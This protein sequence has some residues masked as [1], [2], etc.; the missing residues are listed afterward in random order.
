M[1]SFKIC[2]PIRMKLGLVAIVLL[3]SQY[4][5]CCLVQSS[6]SSVYPLI[7]LVLDFYDNCYAPRPFHYIALFLV[8][9]SINPADRYRRDR[10]NN[11]LRRSKVSLYNE[12]V[13]LCG[14]GF[15]DFHRG[16]HD[17]TGDKRLFHLEL[18]AIEK[19]FK[20]MADKFLD[21]GVKGE[22]SDFVTCVDKKGPFNMC[23]E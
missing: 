11:Y 19:C 9:Q 5:E 2:Q 7:R 20:E 18:Q 13:I 17:V 3:A 4:V 12:G 8:K 21:E 22:R 10:V 6:H 16:V 1:R 23:I 15:S 14:F